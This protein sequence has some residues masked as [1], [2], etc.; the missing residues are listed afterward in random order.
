MIFTIDDKAV[1]NQGFAAG[2]TGRSGMANSYPR[3]VMPIKITDAN[4]LEFQN[5]GAGD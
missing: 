3:G 1:Y 4:F 5:Y 2:V